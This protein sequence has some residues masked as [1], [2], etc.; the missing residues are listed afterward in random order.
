MNSSNTT[1]I[2]LFA[3]IVIS[4]SFLSA[5]ADRFGL[6]GAPGEPSVAWGNWANFIVYSNSVNSFVPIAIGNVLAIAAT[7]IETLLPVL[8]LI[9]YRIRICA[10]AS[11]ILLSCFALAMTISFGFKPPL[12]YSVWSA[13]AGSF[14][15]STIQEYQYSIDNLLARK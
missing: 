9:G 3:R 13:A 7:S 15:L 11:G 5:V 6:W 8:L 10:I 4:F 12:D 2:Q 1:Y 14:L